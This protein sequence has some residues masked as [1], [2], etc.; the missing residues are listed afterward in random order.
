MCEEMTWICFLSAKP[1]NALQAIH[2]CLGDWLDPDL[3]IITTTNKHFGMDVETSMYIHLSELL[4]GLMEIMEMSVEE[5]P[6]LLVT[7]YSVDYYLFQ[8]EK[9]HG[10]NM[11]YAERMYNKD[12]KDIIQRIGMTVSKY[13]ILGDIFEKQTENCTYLQAFAKEYLTT[14]SYRRYRIIN[15]IDLAQTYIR[16]YVLN[17]LAK[18]RFDEI[19]QDIRWLFKSPSSLDEMKDYVLEYLYKRA[20]EGMIERQDFIEK[21][22]KEDFSVL[23]NQSVYKLVKLFDM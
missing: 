10:K 15:V 18:E 1:T 22:G 5:R 8:M 11:T 3:S 12:I 4:F 21:H 7:D 17:A 9:L 16:Q 14:I 6:R 13:F 19:I 23:S 20:C 2:Q